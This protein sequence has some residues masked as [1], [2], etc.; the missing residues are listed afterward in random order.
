MIAT[1]VLN[2]QRMVCTRCA[3]PPRSSYS[4]LQGREFPLLDL[5]SQHVVTNVLEALL[6]HRPHLVQLCRVLFSQPLQPHGVSGLGRMTDHQRGHYAVSAWLKELGRLNLAAE[7]VQVAPCA[8]RVREHGPQ[9]LLKLIARG[10]RRDAPLS[11]S[12]MGATQALAST[13]DSG[14]RFRP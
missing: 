4:P 2:R 8:P 13:A 5:P 3:S 7:R 14:P 12:R 9:L 11:G 6:R 10:R 1:T